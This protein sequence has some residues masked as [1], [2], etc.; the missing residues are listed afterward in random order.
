MGPLV[1]SFRRLF[2]KCSLSTPRAGCRAGHEGHGGRGAPLPPSTRF[3]GAAAK[4]W[5]P[6]KWEQRVPKKRNRSGEPT[7]DRRDLFDGYAGPSFEDDGG[8]EHPR[9]RGEGAEAGTQV[10]G[11]KKHRDS[12]GPRGGPARCG[13]P[14][15]RPRSER[16]TREV[17]TSLVPLSPGRR[18]PAQL[19]IKT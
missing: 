9:S 3:G 12:R 6:N 14:G 17:W 2:Y 4:Q 11:F 13:R 1:R 8:A 16:P 7:A 15:C 18:L 10:S 5:K 19:G